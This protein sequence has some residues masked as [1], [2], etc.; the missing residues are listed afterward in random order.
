MVRL[1]LFSLF[2]SNALVLI[3]RDPGT[4][5][6]PEFK[7]ARP[8][9]EVIAEYQRLDNLSESISLST[10]G[11]TDAGKPL[12]VCVVS[13]DKTFDPVAARAK[14][15]VVI[16]IN[17]AIHPGE[18]D[19]VEACITLMQH[20]SVNPAV[21]PANVVLVIIPVYNIDGYLNR[22]AYSRA[23]QNGPDEYG[24]R[25][26]AKNLDLNRDFIKAD[27]QNTIS[28]EQIFQVWKPHV[29]ID[30]HVSD[31]ADYQYTMTLIATQHNKLHP[32]LG[33]YLNSKLV[34]SVYDAMGKTGNPICPYVETMGETP[35]SGIVGFLES[36]R[37]A[38]GYA[39]LFNCIGFVPETHMLKP[40]SDRVWATFDLIRVIVDKVSADA[41]MIIKN[42]DDAD[43]A[44]MIQKQFTLD[45][46]LDTTQFDLF[47][48]RGY[49]STHIISKV[50]GLPVLYYDK[51]K[52]YNKKVKYYNTYKPSRIVDAP[53]IYIVPQAWSDVIFRLQ[54]NGVRMQR[55]SKDTLIE[56]G[57]YS[58]TK[59]NHP[60]Y[61]YESHYHHRNTQVSKSLQKVL[62]MKGD[63]VVEL[64][65]V[66]NRYIV[67][68]LDP[69]GDDSF[70]AWNFFDSVLNQK[71]WFSDYVF[72]A[73]AEQ[74]LKDEPSIR[75]SMDS[76]RAADTAF[77]K[78]HW[79]QMNFIYQRSRYKE[80]SHNRYPVA[81][82]K[83]ETNLP[84]ER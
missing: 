43:K 29:L 42:R 60:A 15:K 77:A 10:W 65:Q 83:S 1:F 79:A 39:A 84:I 31:G 61:P 40:F 72:D 30:N 36:P 71:E 2:F 8:Y 69:Q 3:G 59:V 11:M 50:T 73:K 58:L 25:A 12:H 48:F 28:F 32:L 78:N 7:G 23:N 9:N 20:V 26:N 33:A 21:V 80:P 57:F 34:P 22:G 63:Y 76:T 56:A 68:T 75:K 74:I 49:E 81:M 54:V 51:T 27:A 18:P 17:N 44:V 4:G 46:Q 41:A 53:S 6:R 16:M 13:A 70:F 55:L 52:P 38:T 64:N 82:L 5:A 62:F 35:E 45:W 66:A 47:D 67:E 37:F 24:F 14:G 19:G